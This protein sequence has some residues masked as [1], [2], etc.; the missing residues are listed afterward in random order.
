MKYIIMCGGNY[1]FSEPKQF[2]KVLDDERI[3]DRTIRLLKENGVEDIAI[4]TNNDAFASCGVPLLKN[5][6][7]NWS[8][9]E[10]DKTKRGYWLDAFYPYQ[11][12]CVYLYGDVFYT[13]R[14]IKSIVATVNTE[15]KKNILYGSA[16]ALNKLHK[17]W[18]EP[19]AYIVNDM[20]TF[21]AG[22]EAVKKLQDE[23]KL[24]REAITWEL[25]RYLNN[26]DVNIHEVKEDTFYAIDDAT[27][28]LDKAE[29]VDLILTKL[30]KNNGK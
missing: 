6:Q 17:N 13:E 27:D 20:P 3:I 18:G 21:R 8:D 16:I 25:Y 5:A 7:N 10:K 2:T 30:G 26:L 11:D 24:L 19:F 22:I 23:G 1:D 12:S 28:D 14:A 9:I 4:S 15:K 29:K